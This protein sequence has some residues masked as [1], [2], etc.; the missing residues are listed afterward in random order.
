ME[1]KINTYEVKKKNCRPWGR[2]VVMAWSNQ[3]FALLRGLD[4]TIFTRLRIYTIN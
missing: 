1:K 3:L 2:Y 4:V